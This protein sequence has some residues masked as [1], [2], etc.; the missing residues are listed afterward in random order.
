MYGYRMGKRTRRFSEWW[1]YTIDKKDLTKFSEHKQKQISSNFREDLFNQV[2]K[3]Y[4]KDKRIKDVGFKRGAKLLKQIYGIEIPQNT[5]RTYRIKY[6]QN[7][8]V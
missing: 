5:Y 3:I 4:Q 6:K 2:S 8:L 1:L 7:E